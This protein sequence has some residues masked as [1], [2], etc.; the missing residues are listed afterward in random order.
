MLELAQLS[1]YNAELHQSCVFIMKYF[2]IKQA[3]RDEE[4]VA[5]G[6]GHA[7]VGTAV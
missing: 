5:L 3:A 6:G 2:G 1:N 4:T 7:G